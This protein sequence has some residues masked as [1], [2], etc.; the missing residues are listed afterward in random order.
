MLEEER[1]EIAH[2]DSVIGLISAQLVEIN[3]R[4]AAAEPVKKRSKS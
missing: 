1:K 2:V 4:L 3:E